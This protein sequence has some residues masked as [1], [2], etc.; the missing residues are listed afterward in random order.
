MNSKILNL[1]SCS[2]LRHRSSSRGKVTKLLKLL[3]ATCVKNTKLVSQCHKFPVLSS[4]NPPTNVHWSVTLRFEF[5]LPLAWGS[6]QGK[7]YC[8]R[9]IS[10]LQTIKFLPGKLPGEKSV[11]LAKFSFF[12][13]TVNKSSFPRAKVRSVTTAIMGWNNAHHIAC[14]AGVFYER[15]LKSAL[16]HHFG[17]NLTRRPLPWNFFFG[18]P[19]ASVSFI[20]QNGRSTNRLPNQIRLLCR[21]HITRHPHKLRDRSYFYNLQYRQSKL[22]TR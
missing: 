4:T 15:S 7:L 12:R 13:E 6:G 10:K 22:T 20:I 11:T 21:L 16:G 5:A 17:S 19:Q 9:D 3:L 2:E 8:S 14:R 1:Q 18:S